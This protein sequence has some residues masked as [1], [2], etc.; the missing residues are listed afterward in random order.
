MSESAVPAETATPSPK[1]T[2][3]EQVSL[4]QDKSHYDILGIRPDATVPQVKQA[5]RDAIRAFH[6]DFRSQR[7]AIEFFTPEA[8]DEMII[9][10]NAAADVLKDPDKRA[11]YDNLLAAQK[12]QCA[13]LVSRHSSDSN[14]WK[15]QGGDAYAWAEGVHRT[16]TKDERSR[17]QD[18][19]FRT[20]AARS[21]ES[22]PS[23]ILS[24]APEPG[25][26]PPPLML[27]SLTQSFPLPSDWED[28]IKRII[29]AQT[30]NLSQ[31][32][33]IPVSLHA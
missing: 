26:P 2:A 9:K 28:S 31:P 15:E 20:T 18:E 32:A 5:S 13:E 22:P 11:K 25:L 10:V 33:A 17:V 14:S 23:A 8:M 4:T 6:P 1:I 12:Q 29:F 24:P 27:E 16:F 7:S 3:P 30:A 19:A 21:L